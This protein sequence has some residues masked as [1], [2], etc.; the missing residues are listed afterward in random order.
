MAQEKLVC[1]YT[2]IAI[3]KVLFPLFFNFLVVY[4]CAIIII[5]ACK[6]YFSLRR[7]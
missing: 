6:G 3:E 2:R 4:F 5:Y 7:S 1:K